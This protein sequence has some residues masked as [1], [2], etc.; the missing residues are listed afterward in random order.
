MSTPQK[1]INQKQQKV[2]LI[3]IPHTIID[4]RTMVIHPGNALFAGRTMMTLRNFYLVALFTHSLENWF[5]VHYLFDSEVVVVFYLGEDFVFGLFSV[6]V[7]RFTYKIWYVLWGFII[8]T[9]YL[10]QNCLILIKIKLY[11]IEP[12]FTIFIYYFPTFL[13]LLIVLDTWF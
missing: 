9:F 8:K 5:Y 4:P 7:G 1:N 11:P 13:C 12:D 10:L 2:F 6:F 3:P